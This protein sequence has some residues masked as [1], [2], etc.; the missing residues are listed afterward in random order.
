MTRAKR[1]RDKPHRCPACHT[2]CDRPGNLY[3]W[4]TLHCERCDLWWFYGRAG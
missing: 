4:S 3:P 1:D 2:S